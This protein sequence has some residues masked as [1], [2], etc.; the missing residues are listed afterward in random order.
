ME[1]SE[2]FDLRA[3]WGESPIVGLEAQEVEAALRRLAGAGFIAGNTD[4]DMWW[5]LRL[6]PNGL[7]YFDEWPDVENAVSSATIRRVLR[8]LAEQAPSETRDAVARTAGVVGR[9][10]DGILR[11]ALAEIAHDAGGDIVG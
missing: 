11:D 5:R 3:R 1:T 9:T 4:A 6:A 10:V 7:R 2:I 8:E